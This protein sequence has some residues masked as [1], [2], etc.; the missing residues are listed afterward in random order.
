M[1]ILPVVRPVLQLFSGSSSRKPIETI[2]ATFILTTYAYFLLLQAAKHSKFLAPSSPFSDVKPAV[3]V[4]REG[5]GWINA[6]EELWSSANPAWSKVEF[7]QVVVSLDPPPSRTIY[8]R[9]VRYSAFDLASPSVHDALAN[10][11]QYLTTSYAGPIGETYPTVCYI[12]P[13]EPGS[14]F[15]STT[16]PSSPTR[17]TTLTLAFA[18]PSAVQW[19]SGL[20]GRSF[21]SGDLEFSIERDEARFDTMESG[22]WV[23]YAIRAMV[24]RF[25]DLARKA[26]S[27]DIFVVLLG[28]LL[29]HGVFVNLFMKA[30]KLGSNFW[31][32]RF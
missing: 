6:A 21:P 14:C 30:R 1:A 18:P 23:G 28:Y 17:S 20:A 12:A 29:M 9:P 27:A 24:L 25:W 13:S 8:D 16:L 15:S 22:K 32:G 11:T 10:F 26:D 19:A 4:F 2:V 7:Q 31:L 5:L 3:A